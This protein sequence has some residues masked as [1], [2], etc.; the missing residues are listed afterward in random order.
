MGL[1]DISKRLV[2]VE[3]QCDYMKRWVTVNDSLLSR[4]SD[5]DQRISNLEGSQSFKFSEKMQQYSALFGGDGHGFVYFTDPHDMSGF[6][7]YDVSLHFSA[8]RTVYS[9]TPARYV[10]CGG[11]WL[12]SKHTLAEAKYRVG[13]VP[14]MMRTEICQKSYTIVGNHDLNTENPVDEG[15]TEEELARIWYESDVCYFTVED[16]DTL[17]FMLDSGSD[18]DTM[19]AYRWTQVDWFGSQLLANTKT[20]LFGVIHIIGHGPI[21]QYP[22]PRTLGD[23]IT[24]IADAFNQRSSV[25]VNGITYNFANATGTFHFMLAGHYHEDHRET[26]NNI[27]IFYSAAHRAIDCC[28]ADWTNSKIS[29]LRT[30]IGKNLGDDREYPIIPSGGYQA[31]EVEE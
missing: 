12:N 23:K 19:T 15:M 24:L 5:F 26:E 4:A 25:T 9:N 13:R 10:L 11:D 16:S 1:V 2:D 22:T 7:D 28:Y 31:A 3:A 14:N 20:H 21:N 29:M 6:E 30:G 27:P 18:N 8:L 17:C